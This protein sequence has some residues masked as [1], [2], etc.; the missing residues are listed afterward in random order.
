LK[1]QE[2]LAEADRLI[3]VDRAEQYGPVNDNFGRI[4]ALWSAYLGAPIS[5]ADVAAL[6]VL[7]KAARTAAAPS[8]VDSWVDMAG[9]A[10]LGGEISCG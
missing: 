7:L 1:R 6:M 8:H 4:A 9:Y 3:S 5:M 10:A 2:V